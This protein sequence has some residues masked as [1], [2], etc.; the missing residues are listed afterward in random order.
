MNQYLEKLNNTKVDLQ[1]EILDLQ[2]R[3]SQH[4]QSDQNMPTAQEVL[5]LQSDIVQQ[6][7][8]IDFNNK[9]DTNGTLVQPTPRTHNNAPASTPN[10]DTTASVASSHGDHGIHHESNPESQV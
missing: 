5:Q 8:Q 10:F 4:A 7:R 1:Q 3:V 6:K 9:P 2:T